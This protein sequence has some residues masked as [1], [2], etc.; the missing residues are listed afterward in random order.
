MAVFG[1]NLIIAP[2]QTIICV[3]IL[4]RY[5]EWA[6]IGGIVVLCLFIPFQAMM[7]RLF[8][9]VRRITS[10]LTDERIRVMSEVISGMRV[11]KMYSWEKAFADIV[12]ECRR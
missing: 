4:W 5:L 8:G 12:N 9:S 7:G 3:V 2:L 1:Y 11:I 10:S 6:C